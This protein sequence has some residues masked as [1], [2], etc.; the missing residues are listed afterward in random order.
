MVKFFFKKGQ[1]E[2]G[3]AELDLVLNTQ[4]RQSKGF[5]GFVSLLSRTEKDVA[6]VLTFWA[7]DES[8]MASERAVYDKVVDKIYHLLEK[9]PEVEYYRVFSTELRFQEKP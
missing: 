9:Q 5:R 6:L 7:D 8:L 2:E 1:C 3:F 4:A